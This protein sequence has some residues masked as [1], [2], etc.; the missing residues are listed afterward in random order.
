LLQVLTLE[1][2]DVEGYL[3]LLLEAGMAMQQPA[4]KHIFTHGIVILV[5]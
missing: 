2:K 1:E 3:L 5:M 4:S